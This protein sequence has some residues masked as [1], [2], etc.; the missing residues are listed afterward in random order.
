[1]QKGISWEFFQLSRLELEQ[2][3]EPGDFGY[4]AK[5]MARW[6]VVPY[7]TFDGDFNVG[8]VAFHINYIDRVEFSV[9]G[10]PWL[11]VYTMSMNSQINVVEY[12]ATLRASDFTDGP[13]ELRA[14]AYPK[15]GIPRVLDSLR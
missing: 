6:D 2:L 8:V 1:M 14:V 12:W 9:N 3:G 13:L 11:P 4:D 7:Q 5:A 10:G 15:V